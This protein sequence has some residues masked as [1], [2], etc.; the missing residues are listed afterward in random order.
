MLHKK[1]GTNA[2]RNITTQTLDADV[3]EGVFS[4]EKNIIIGPGAITAFVFIKFTRTFLMCFAK[5]FVT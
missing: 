5:E 2:A 1:G 4:N 3:H